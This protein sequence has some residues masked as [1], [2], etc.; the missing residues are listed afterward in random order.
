MKG[1]PNRH[2]LPLAA[3]IDAVLQRRKERSGGAAEASGV[4]MIK[5]GRCDSWGKRRGLS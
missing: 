2:R 4:T 1:Q 3:R 5:G